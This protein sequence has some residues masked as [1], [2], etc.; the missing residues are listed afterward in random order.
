MRNIIRKQQFFWSFEEKIVS[1]KKKEMRVEKHILRGK[2]INNKFN[3]NNK[4]MENNHEL[5]DVEIKGK[6]FTKPFIRQ[7]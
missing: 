2:N 1:L 3:K 6:N 5:Y 4:K 7:K